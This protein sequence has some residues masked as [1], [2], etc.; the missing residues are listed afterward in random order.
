M[1]WRKKMK[2]ILWSIKQITIWGGKW[3]VMYCGK[4]KYMGEK[5]PLYL[6]LAGNYY[7]IQESVAWS[8]HNNFELNINQDIYV[9]I[10]IHA[11][12]YH[13][14]LLSHCIQQSMNKFSNIQRY[15]I[16]A[17]YDE[18]RWT[19]LSKKNCHPFLHFRFPTSFQKPS[20]VCVLWL[21][22][23]CIQLSVLKVP[24]D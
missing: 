17:G 24:E 2:F 1:C 8:T 18:L 15:I 22:F 11:T 5:Y 21:L 14:Q 10:Y 12:W 4:C 19:S 20:S 9:Y 16:I 3:I 23:A 6:P 13:V 7:N